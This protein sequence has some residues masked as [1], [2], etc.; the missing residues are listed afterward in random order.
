MQRGQIAHD[1]VVPRVPELVRLL[2]HMRLRAHVAR[3]YP[4][5]PKFIK[6]RI[7]RAACFVF[8]YLRLDPVFLQ[9]HFDKLRYLLANLAQSLAYRLYRPLVGDIISASKGGWR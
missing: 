7:K 1:P 6:S 4:R 3:K 2:D 8:A 5:L 9:H